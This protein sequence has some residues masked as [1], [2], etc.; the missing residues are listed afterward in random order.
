M[1]I[2]QLLLCI[3]SIALCTLV[4]LPPICTHTKDPNSVFPIEFPSRL[5]FEKHNVALL[6]YGEAAKFL[7]ES[8]K[9]E[10]TTYTTPGYT[11]RNI[12]RRPVP[13]TSITYPDSPPVYMCRI[14]IHHF[15]FPRGRRSLPLYVNANS[16]IIHSAVHDSIN[17]Y[18][19]GDVSMYVYSLMG[20]D[21]PAFLRPHSKDIQTW[22]S[23][24]HCTRRPDGDEVG[25]YGYSCSFLLPMCASI[26]DPRWRYNCI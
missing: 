8:S 18:I 9:A 10:P 21:N 23:D 4:F 15:I 14:H 20:F 2:A 25:G 22:A 7:F 19:E 5:V 3:K 1:P 16:A 12:N 11:A 13:C 26:A 6:V 24:I 17:I